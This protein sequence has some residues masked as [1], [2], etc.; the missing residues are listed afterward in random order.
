METTFIGHAA[1]LTKL[2][3]LSIISDPWWMGPCFGRQWWIYPRPALDRLDLSAIDYI[4]IS[5]GHADH[6]HAGTIRR[7]PKGTKVLVAAELNL[8]ASLRD[9]GFAVIEV[10]PDVE[11]DLGNGVRCRIIPTYGDD[12]LMT[13]T[14]GKE[15]LFNLND[16]L[17]AAPI[18]VQDSVMTHLKTLY[19]IIDYAFCGYGIASHFPNCYFIPGKDNVRT[20]IARQQ[21]FNR[22]WARVIA[23]LE[24]RFGFPFAADVVLLQRD[25]F[26]A[27]EPVR[28]AE[29]PTD[30]FASLHPSSPTKVLDIAPG[31]VIGDGQVRDPKLFE[32]IRGVDIAATYREEYDADEAGP[33]RQS[34]DI[35][36]L[37]ERL[38][39]NIE[40]ARAYLREFRGDY[41]FLLAIR[42]SDR[43][44]EM[45]KRGNDISAKAMTPTAADRGACDL[46]FTTMFSY[47][48]RTFTTPYGDE[49]LFVGSGCTIQYNDA[50]RVRENLHRE[51][52]AVLKQLK[53]PPRSR[54][55]DQP[56]LLYEV[57]QGIKQL[58]GRKGDD[59]Y[60]L[61]SWT[62]YQSPDAPS[63]ALAGHGSREGSR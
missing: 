62:V 4:Y 52:L 60:D 15:V 45:R 47:L 53:R 27:N 3:G 35:E 12:S 19:P 10:D 43:A 7:F 37:C 8:G 61:D 50:A 28:N 31:F 20:A 39:Q 63:G 38:N 5:H 58:V 49:T 29:R 41:A 59:L 1:I 34:Y 30:V 33:K 14:D 26:W 56:R 11:C 16:A 55:G 40:T 24:P 48:R 18:S 44:I 9:M 17:H 36:F 57:K 23:R 13:L 25:L 22:R 32:P 46:V 51:L 2:G 6:L 21:H 54:F 42:G